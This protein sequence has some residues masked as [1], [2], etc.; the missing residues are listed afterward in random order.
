[1]KKFIFYIIATVLLFAG[2]SKEE[3]PVCEMDEEVAIEQLGEVRTLSLTA[4]MPEETNTRVVLEKEEDNNIKLTWEEGDELQLCFVQ[5]YSKVKQVVTINNITNEGKKASFDVL[6]PTE[7]GDDNFDLYGVYGGGGLLD[8]DPTLAVLP[9]NPSSATSLS[10]LSDGE[11]AML[12]F[13]AKEINASSSVSVT[14]EHIG[15]LF[16]LTLKNATA[17][18]I[19]NLGQARLTSTTGGWAYNSV[20]SGKSYNL[21]SNQFQDVEAAGNYISLYADGAISP[22]NTLSFWGGYPPLTD[23]NWPALTL[24]LYDKSNTLIG[25]SSNA[26]PAR[27]APTMAGK[28]FYFYAMMNDAGLHF[29]DNTFILPPA[30]E[31][32]TVTGD[33]RHADSGTDF[34]GMVYTRAGNVY[35][36]QAQLSGVWTGEVNLG[37]GSDAR[38]AVDSNDKT[39]VV[40]VNAGKIA[41]CTTT[42]GITF[43]TEY[44]ESGNGGSCSSPDIAVDG[45]GFAH[46]TYSDTRGGSDTDK[47]IEIMY[48]VN[49]SGAFTKT[50]IYDGEYYDRRG[51]YY[52]KGSRIEVDS[53]GKYFILTHFRDYENSMGGTYN[54]YYLKVTS[55]TASGS[56]V[57]SSSDNFDIYDMTFDGADVVAFYKSNNLVTTAKLTVSGNKISFTNPETVT[58]AITNSYTAPA[59][60]VVLPTTRVLAGVSAGKVFTKY[61]TEEQV[62]DKTVKSA[63]VVV[64]TQCGGNIYTAYTGSADGII[65][66][67]KR[68]E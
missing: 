40:Y 37:A 17:S 6:I 14:F 58:T 45:D 9:T 46:I 21:V 53:N 8:S 18:S 38:I 28:C 50:I 41:Y 49:S 31:D 51:S 68:A 33:L 10:A 63:T 34:I 48:A 16:C 67:I 42:D 15:S 20:E 64:A 5:G 23:V 29:T 13:A 61:G 19:D 25:T 2:C 55:A 12:R 35:Y 36:N 59:T 7:F 32:L 65:R 24:K 4:N 22:D 43:T 62:S 11:Y 54:S 39:H 56:S 66:L 52:D 3:M 1:M 44:I 26:K 27:T 60:L 57:Y 47:Y 30:M